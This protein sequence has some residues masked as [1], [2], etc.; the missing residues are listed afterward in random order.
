VARVYGRI[1]LADPP[2][3]TIS[4]TRNQGMRTHNLTEKHYGFIVGE[5]QLI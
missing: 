4:T 5:F 2:T 3:G 1:L